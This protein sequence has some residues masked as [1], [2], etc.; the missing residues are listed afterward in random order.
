ME[1]ES[2]VSK[3]EF[4]KNEKNEATSAIYPMKEI[5]KQDNRKRELLGGS[6]SINIITGGSRFEGLGVPIGLY[7]APKQLDFQSDSTKN[8]KECQVM[9][10]ESFDKLFRK[11]AVVHNG[12]INNITKRNRKKH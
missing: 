3:Y 10:N 1:G 12:K 2:H 7:V 5:L 11:I 8:K 6:A 4:N 9:D